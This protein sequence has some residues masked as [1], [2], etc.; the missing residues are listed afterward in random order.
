MLLRRQLPLFPPEVW[1]VHVTTLRN[2]ECT[3]NAC[4]SWN[5][6]FASLVSHQHPSIWVLL[7]AI[8]MDEVMALTDIAAEARG[9]PPIKRATVQHQ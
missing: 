3:N 9:Q 1:N 7:D 4:E 5:D 8:P 2:E 6:A